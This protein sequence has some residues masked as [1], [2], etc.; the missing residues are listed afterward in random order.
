MTELG[1][2]LEKDGAELADNAPEPYEFC[3]ACYPDL[4]KHFWASNDHMLL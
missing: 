2:E 4:V 1:I 3:M